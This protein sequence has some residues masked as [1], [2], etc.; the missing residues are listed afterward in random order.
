MR[1][2]MRQVVTRGTA[3]LADVS[4]YEV[5]GKTGTAD[6]PLPTGGYARD[7]VIST[8]AGFFPA[9]APEYVLVVAFDEPSTAINGQSFRTAGLTTVPIA[10]KVIRRIAP[11]LG[12]RPRPAPEEA[13]GPLYTLAGND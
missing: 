4:G 10:A 11:I 7:K 6:K 3:K 2:L 5:A 9:D 8:F 13:A 12:L 1:G